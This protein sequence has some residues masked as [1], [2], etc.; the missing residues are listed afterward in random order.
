MS[1]DG[2]MM[3]PSIGQA[4]WLIS[5]ASRA[6]SSANDKSCTV[7]IDPTIWQRANNRT[8]LQNRI[9]TLSSIQLFIDQQ[10]ALI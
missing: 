5:S 10:H 4:M 9:L 8:R 6:V 7:H 2:H 3:V 1:E